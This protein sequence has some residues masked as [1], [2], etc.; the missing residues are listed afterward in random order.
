MLLAAI[1]ATVLHEFAHAF[2]ALIL[3]CEVTSIVIGRLGPS[4]TFTA[5]SLEIVL[6]LLPIDGQTR[7][8]PQS[9]GQEFVILSAGPLINLAVGGGCLLAITPPGFRILFLAIFGGINV[10]AGVVNL[11]PMPAH[12]PKKLATDGWRLGGLFIGTK[13][14]RN[15][16]RAV[17]IRNRA[18]ALVRNSHG[19]DPAIEFVRRAREGAAP[20][21]EVDWLLVNLLLSSPSNENVLEGLTLADQVFESATDQ[22]SDV[23]DR[24]FRS[25]LANSIA[26]A[27]VKVP[28]PDPASLAEADR[29]ATFACEIQ[30]NSPAPVDTLAL[31]RVRQ[32]RYAEAE[33]MIRPLIETPMPDAHRANCETTLALALAGLGR[34]EEASE[35]MARA[36][37]VDCP[38]PLLAEA[39]SVIG[40]GGTRITS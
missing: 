33:S 31:V 6:H 37:A 23:G 12:P 36:R 26:Y 5:G 34:Y 9:R 29:K 18:R 38:K 16:R 21:Q 4:R 11:V 25:E 10:F 24:L 17:W 2:A 27:L 32:R 22:V 28:K 20:N 15:R 40:T 14:A 35:V 3:G 13:E 7:C 1:L 19:C 39:E 8:L 30:P